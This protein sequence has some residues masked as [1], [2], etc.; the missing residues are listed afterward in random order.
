MRDGR[1]W[2]RRLPTSETSAAE[3][4]RLMVGR[5]VLLRVEET[6][7]AHAGR[8]DARRSRPVGQVRGS[9]AP[10]ERR[11]VRGQRRRDRRHRRRRGQRTDGADRGALRA[12]ST[13]RTHVRARSGSKA[14]IIT[15]SGAR[16]APGAAASRTSPK[17][18]T[19]AVWCSTSTSRRTRSSA[20]TIA[21]RSWAPGGV[22]AADTSQAIHRRATDR[23]HRG[24]SSTC[25]RRIRRCRRARCPA[26]TSKS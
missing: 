3:L 26:A 24:E 17:T 2:S 1:T 21:S 16:L 4:A 6:P 20:C 23:D 15:R 19:G 12:W 10:R 8:D 11:L 25:V 22:R 13:R 14:V 9:I 7:R 18:G 5:E